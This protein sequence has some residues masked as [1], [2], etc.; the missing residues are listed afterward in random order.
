MLFLFCLDLINFVSN[1]S[2]ETNLV[3]PYNTMK[4]IVK[5][6]FPAN[7]NALLING[8]RFKMVGLYFSR[9]KLKVLDTIIEKPLDIAYETL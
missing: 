3:L 1:F 2:S 9:S 4:D 5:M 7:S 8:Q 6:M